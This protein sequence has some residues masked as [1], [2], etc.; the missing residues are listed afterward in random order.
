MS[1]KKGTGLP[2]V[3]LESVGCVSALECESFRLSACVSMTST[4]V[5][6]LL[7]AL[8]GIVKSDVGEQYQKAS[9]LLRKKILTVAFTAPIASCGRVKLVPDFDNEKMQKKIYDG[10]QAKLSNLEAN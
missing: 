7:D 2:D 1:K 10:Y 6:R 4:D 5:A 8:A 3:T 9:A